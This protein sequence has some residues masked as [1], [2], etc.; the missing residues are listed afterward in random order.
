MKTIEIS[1]E[2][3][4]YEDAETG[5][6]DPLFVQVRVLVNGQ[7]W[8]LDSPV[9]NNHAQITRAKMS[10]LLAG[11]SR[12]KA[13]PAEVENKFGIPALNI[14]RAFRSEYYSFCSF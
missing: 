5:C 9:S 14:E 1:Y 8:L 11:I 12:I 10:A 6:V 3:R 4:K 2:V 7:G 13:F